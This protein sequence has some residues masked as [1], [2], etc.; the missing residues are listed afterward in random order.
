MEPAREGLDRVVLGGF[1]NVAEVLGVGQALVV[2]QA[3]R[4]RRGG[5]VVVAGVEVLRRFRHCRQ[6]L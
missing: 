3:P 4:G 2:V 5:A 6:I 1:Y